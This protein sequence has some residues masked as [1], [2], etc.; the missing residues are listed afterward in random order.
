MTRYPEGDK[1]ALFE[2]IRDAAADRRSGASVALDTLIDTVGW[3]GF[4]DGGG[5]DLFDLLSDDRDHPR[6]AATIREQFYALPAIETIAPFDSTIRAHHP[7]SQTGA[8]WLLHEDILPFISRWR[9][10]LLDEA[11][12]N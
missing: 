6:L 12:E 1:H 3:R 9:A 10:V 7:D 2:V 8:D 4:Y 5:N 11:A